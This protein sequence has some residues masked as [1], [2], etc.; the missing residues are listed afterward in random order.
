MVRGPG[1][2]LEACTQVSY[3]FCNV[4]PPPPPRNQQ[5]DQLDPQSRS[6]GFVLVGGDVGTAHRRR[7]KE[8]EKEEEEEARGALTFGDPVAVAVE[9]D[10]REREN[11]ETF[12]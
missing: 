2:G 11:K 4:M 10:F 8:K 3:D 12:V 6:T 7:K 5:M 1:S 9:D